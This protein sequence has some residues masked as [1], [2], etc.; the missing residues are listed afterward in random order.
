MTWEKVK[1]KYVARISK[2]VPSSRKK[3]AAGM[4]ALEQVLMKSFPEV[5]ENPFLLERQ[6]VRSIIWNQLGN[7][8]GLGALKKMDELLREMSAINKLGEDFTADECVFTRREAIFCASK[9]LEHNE[10]KN[11][12]AE[13]LGNSVVDIT[14][15]KEGVKFMGVAIGS[16]NQEVEVWVTRW[17]YERKKE[18]RLNRGAF[19]GG[20]SIALLSLM[21]QLNNSKNIL[22]VIMVPH[23]DVTRETVMKYAEYIKK[24]GIK[25]YLVKSAKEITEV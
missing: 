10:W 11:I 17:S 5:I 4:L 14:A 22:P 15:E 16:V 24:T 19:R 18:I 20:L 12:D 2:L 7:H 13:Q 1:E 3:A 25:I 8:D 21:D 9:W 23:D 6:A